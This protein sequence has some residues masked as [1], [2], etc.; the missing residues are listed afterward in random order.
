MSLF[1]T[2]KTTE[3]GQ[4]KPAGLSLGGKP[5]QQDDSL[6]EKKGIL[7]AAV[8]QAAAPAKSSSSGL[9]FGKKTQDTPK[10]APLE[11]TTPKKAEPAPRAS[12]QEPARYTGPE[13]ENTK[14]Q[15]I[16]AAACEIAFILEYENAALKNSDFDVVNNVVEQKTKLVKLYEERIEEL[17][18]NPELGKSFPETD[19][20]LLRNIGGKLDALMHENSNLLKSNV[21]AI[22]RLMNS[23]IDAVKEHAQ[24]KASSYSKQGQ[25]ASSAKDKE[26]LSVTFNREL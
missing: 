8:S 6:G 5:S 19:R 18:A 3:P 26:Q 20:E 1:K 16:H 13:P 10:K 23:V 11:A 25:L 21:K 14:A 15:V 22:E 2:P 9:A 17:K 24:E 4:G 7:G 12:T